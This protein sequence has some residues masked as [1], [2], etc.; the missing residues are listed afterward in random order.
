ML[1]NGLN[2][3]Y[4]QPDDPD[5]LSRAFQEIGTLEQ[6]GAA[7]NP[8]ILSYHACTSLGATDDETP[9]CSSFMCWIMAQEKITSTQSAASLSW[10]RWGRI[11]TKPKRG[12]VV[13]FE[14]VDKQGNV[15]PNRGHVALWLG[16]DNNIT[17]CLGGNQKNAVGVNAY[18]TDRVIGYRWPATVTNSTTNKASSTAVIATTLTA[19]PTLVQISQQLTEATE[20]V[21]QFKDTTH[22]V[23][24]QISGALG[25]VLGIDP[26]S[27]VSL[28]G[29]CVAVAAMLYVIVERSRK[30]KQHGL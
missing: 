6:Q 16:Q 3:R 29:L 11:L 14:R 25:T 22:Q 2:P 8:R 26:A 30:I 13:I 18:R 10:M 23:S 12:C 1:N 5:W 9:W 17:Y 20:P 15:I 4:P 27:I 28:V 24:E 19:A 7:H 21:R